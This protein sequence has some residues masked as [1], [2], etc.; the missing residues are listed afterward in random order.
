MARIR[1]IKPEMPEDEVLG[2]CSRDARLLFVLLLTQADDHGRFR[3]SPSLL[4]GKLFP[5]DDDVTAED[6]SSWTAELIECGRLEAWEVRGQQYAAFTNWKKHQRVDNAGQTRIPDPEDE[7]PGQVDIPQSA[8]NCGES[9]LDLGPRTE[10]LGPR[11]T[12]A[13]RAPSEEVEVGYDFELFWRQYPRKTGKR[14]AEQAYRRARRRASRDEID[15]GLVAQLA[16]WRS[17][18]PKY[19]PHPTTWLN[20]DGWLDEPDPISAPAGSARTQRNAAARE[21]VMAAIRGGS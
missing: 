18:E 2:A 21:Q 14:T 1:S 13:R 8:A 11:T 16:S 20:R 6:V 15:S 12:L 19:V 9:P 10:D 5:Y 7:T 4:R 3:A 17:R